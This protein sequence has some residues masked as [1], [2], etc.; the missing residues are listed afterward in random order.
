MT[1]M[2]GTTST[3]NTDWRAPLQFSAEVEALLNAP[4]DELPDFSRDDDADALLAMAEVHLLKCKATPVKPDLP[5]GSSFPAAASLH[6][7]EAGSS[8]TPE[9][10]ACSSTSPVQQKAS[11]EEIRALLRPTACMSHVGGLTKGRLFT[12]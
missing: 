11:P 3:T 2:T 6:P 9:P 1:G 5:G 4:D 7:S 10:A 12:I 8:Q